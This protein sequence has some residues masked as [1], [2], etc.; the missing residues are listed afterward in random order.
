M[1][2]QYHMLPV[3]QEPLDYHFDALRVRLTSP[4]VLGSAQCDASLSCVIE[5]LEDLLE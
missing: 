5:T 1:D 4:S 2:F 3:A